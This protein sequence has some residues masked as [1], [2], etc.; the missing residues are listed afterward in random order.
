MRNLLSAILTIAL[1]GI[2]HP[3]LAQEAGDYRAVAN[4]AWS[5]AATWE[6]FD[7]TDWTAAAMAPTGVET[8][9]IA[10]DDTVTVN[11]LVSV[12]GTVR[13]SEQGVLEVGAGSLEFGDGSTYEHARD[14]GAVPLASWG[15]GSTFLLTGT[16]QDAPANRNQSFHHVTINTPDL[17]RN[18]DLSL[19]GVTIGGDVHIVD[20]GANRWQ[21][22]SASGGESASFEILGDVIMDAGNFA[23]QGTGNALTTFEVHHHGDI[24]VNGGNFS[25]ARGSQGEGSGTTTW[26]LY[27]GDF[28]MSDASTQN[29]NPTSGNAKF[30]F[31][32]NGTQQLSFTNVE[33]VSG[34][35]NFEVSDSTTLEI[36]SDLDVNGLLV[37]RGEIVPQGTLTFLDGSVYEHARDEGTIPDATWAEGSTALLT[38][39]TSNAP[40]NRGQDYYNLTLNTP[41]L[42]S[43]R[44]MDLGGVTIGGDLSVLSSGSSRWRL[45][46]GDSAE[47]TIMG[48]VI[49]RD[50]SLETQGTSS[51]SEVIIHHYGN[52]D[53][54]GGNLS[55]SRGSQGGGTGRT[56]WYLHEGDFMMSNAR[57][58]N[59]NPT[60]G[61]ARFVF[62]GDSVQTLM[63]GPGNTIDNLSIEVASTATLDLGGT[64]LAGNGI[65]W[66]EDDATIRTA[67][68]GGLD[69]LFAFSGQ[70]DLGGSPGV[71]FNGSLPQQLGGMFTDTLGV[72]TID[73][74]Q[75]VTAGDTSYV[76]SLVVT[77]GSALVVDSTGSITAGGGT[78]DGS[79]LNRGEVI[80]ENA[81]DF[82]PTSRY[83]HA[84]NEGTMPTGNWGEGSTVVMSGVIGDPPDNRNQ[85]YHHLIFNTPE[86]SSNEHMDLNGVTI[87][88]DITVLNTG[89][90]RWYLTSASAEDTSSVTL[91]G[92]VIVQDGQFAAHGTGNAL[93]TIIVDHYGDVIVTGGNFSVSRGSQGDG[94]GTTTWTLH[95]G[96]FSMSNATTQNSNAAGAKF[97]FAGENQQL[98]LREGNTLNA[99]PIEVASG[100]TLDVGESEIAGSGIFVLNE[101]ATLVTAHPDGVAGS[102]QSTGEVTLDEG[103][104]FTFNGTSPQV[105]STLMPTTVNDVT[106]DNEEGVTLSQETTVN[107][108]L[109]IL[110]GVFDNT[111]PFTLGPEGELVRDGGSILVNTGIEETGEMPKEFALHQNYPNPFN[112]STM[113]GYDVKEATDVSVVVY[114]LMGRMVAELVNER[115]AAGR[116][117]VEWNAGHLASG[118]YY[119]QIRAGDFTATR[120]LTLVK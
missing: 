30:V 103:A 70:L 96:N 41:D 64:S 24:I 102:I 10:G 69:S 120:S 52:I 29:S 20:T 98:T 3:V 33:Y 11:V 4:G 48:N 16:V 115:H 31:A 84:R 39:I 112:P 42:S 61:N 85:S 79:I 27:G 26:Y 116:Y 100:T 22:T 28:T 49:V 73:N 77:E 81:L 113:I 9:S 36:T 54:D 6:T 83:E 57:T 88:G 109:L 40:D 89:S 15:S 47:V 13:V 44:D 92:D 117:Q 111:I 59:S 105:T 78:I 114:D 99:L 60:P 86:M 12:S 25:V 2:A 87:S 108:T 35:T 51:P 82:G 71:V 5:D 37:N 62:A 101:G 110:A 53:V 94:S 68:P 46:G 21:L 106:A 104:N 1:A 80:A 91:L 34:K 66:M 50:A 8:I 7:G 43:N 95:E 58:Q 107:G 76:A 56:I 63:L 18:R 23:V 19:D 93:T 17:G 118:I 32:G 97:V 65:F 38:G 119:Y 45:V 14:A 67:H 75:G 72:L 90:A 74:E 55:I